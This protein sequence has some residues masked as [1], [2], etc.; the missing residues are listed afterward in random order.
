[1][2]RAFELCS[3]TGRMCDFIVVLLSRFYRVLPGPQVRTRSSCA[4][5]QR[6]HIGERGAGGGSNKG[7][8][9]TLEVA[10]DVRDDASRLRRR[11]SRAGHLWP[12]EEEKRRLDG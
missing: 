5:P 12:Q 8:V 2:C 9:F 4:N 11:V 7:V 6:T 1:M 3:Q 10:E